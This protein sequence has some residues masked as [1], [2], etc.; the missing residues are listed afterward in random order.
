MR[1]IVKWDIPSRAFAKV[2]D[3]FFFRLKCTY[4]L[5]LGL[6]RSIKFSVL[7]RRMTSE[8][9]SDGERQRVKERRKQWKYLRFF[10]G[11]GECICIN[12][13]QEAPSKGDSWRREV[14]GAESEI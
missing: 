10:G 3:V 1:F 2:G 5:M 14:E 4:V 7:S 9:A 13:S 12:A 6:Y 8:R 11:A